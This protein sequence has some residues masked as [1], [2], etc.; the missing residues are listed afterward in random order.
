MPLEIIGKRP[1]YCFEST[2]SEEG[3]HWV[4][5]QTRWVLRETRW[6]RFGPP[7]IGRKELTEFSPRTSVRAKKLTEFGVWTC[8]PRN[9]IRPV[10]ELRDCETPGFHEWPPPLPIYHAVGNYYPEAFQYFMEKRCVTYSFVVDNMNILGNFLLFVGQDQLGENCLAIFPYW[11]SQSTLRK[12]M[13]Y[14]FG[15]HGSSKQ[16]MYATISA[17]M[18]LHLNSRKILVSVKFVSAILGPEMGAS[19]LWTPGENAFF[20]QEKP[21]SIKFLVLGGG[22]FGFWGGGECRI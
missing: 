2:V 8:A 21:M 10:S 14:I 6:V 19:T 3:T 13:H 15:E 4:L 18:V 16:I 12:K 7:I 20:L 17:R 1:E 22:Y 11:G 9:R 5:R